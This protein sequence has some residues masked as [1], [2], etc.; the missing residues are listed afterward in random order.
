MRLKRSMR[1]F[2]L[3]IVGL[4]GSDKSGSGWSVPRNGASTTHMIAGLPLGKSCVG[5]NARIISWLTVAPWGHMMIRPGL[6]PSFSSWQSHDGSCHEP[7]P[8]GPIY[9]IM[10]S[11]SFLA[12]WTLESTR[13]RISSIISLLAQTRDAQPVGFRQRVGGIPL[14]G[15]GHLTSRRW[16]VASLGVAW[17]VKMWWSTFWSNSRVDEKTVVCILVLLRSISKLDYLE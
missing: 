1:T 13:T 14:Q 5:W 16:M 11:M 15:W 9:S 10:T 6:S 12:F 17:Y 7:H 2:W 4:T 8:H 3:V